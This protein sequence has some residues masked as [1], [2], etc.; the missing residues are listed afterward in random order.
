MARPKGSKNRPK[1]DAPPAGGGPGHNSGQS[2]E[3]LDDDRLHALTRHHMLKRAALITAE[4]SAK[5][6][7]MN[8]DKT[9]KA[10]LG[11]DGLKDIKLL[12]ELSNP[13]N[14]AAREK[15]VQ[16][17][18]Q[19]QLRVAR[20]AGMAIGDQGDLFGEDTRS[21]REKGFEMGKRDGM[22]G[23]PASPPYS[24]QT[25]GSIGYLEGYQEGQKAIFSIKPVTTPDDAPGII[26]GTINDGNGP[27][28]F[29]S[30][31]DSDAGVSSED[32][33]ETTEETE[34]VTEVEDTPDPTES[35]EDPDGTPWPDEVQIES[36]KNDGGDDEAEAAEEPEAETTS[37][38]DETKI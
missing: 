16:N 32:E 1:S 34:E 13:D 22:E 24:P 36:R 8:Y 33:A 6:S 10:D 4:K 26:S 35:R 17:E 2:V 18:V 14:Q 7:R 3:G 12:E 5:A 25:E 37:D 31:S 19:R 20:W 28:E 30:S 9:I 15:D 21:Q 11:S 23:K 27:D 38:D 29:D